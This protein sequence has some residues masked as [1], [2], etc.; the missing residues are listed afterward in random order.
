[1]AL[2]PNNIVNALLCLGLPTNPNAGFNLYGQTPRQ[3]QAN[4]ASQ[5]L[6]SVSAPQE[7][8]VLE[9]LTN[10]DAAKYDTSVITD[11]RLKAAASKDRLLLKRR[12][13]DA[14]GFDPSAANGNT[15]ASIGRG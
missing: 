6:N 12:L 10:W 2:T 9:I 7:T 8:V 1:M 5:L 11:A 4:L 15:G 14:I 3:W 13:Q